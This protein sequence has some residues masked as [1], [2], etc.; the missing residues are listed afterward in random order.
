MNYIIRLERGHIMGKKRINKILFVVLLVIFLGAGA[1]FWYIND[2]YHSDEDVKNYLKGNEK[3]SVNEISQGLFIDGE[4]TENALIFYPGAKVEYIAYLPML[5]NMA[6]QGIDCFLIEMPCNLAFLG[7][8]TAD[9]IIRTYDYENWYMSGH[10]LGGAMA[11]VYASEHLDEL[12]GLVLLAA[13]PTK[14]L[15]ND[16]FEVL[17]IYGSEDTVLNMNSF[18]EGLKYMPVNYKEVCIEGGNHAYFGNY[19]EQEG[20]SKALISRE[21]QQEQTMRAVLE[22]ME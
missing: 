3:V 17:S 15:D 12:E 6:E 10:S 22:I 1:A 4:G 20:D 14:S 16:K 21:E 19:G 18:E 8:N 13:Y 2:Y 11:A 9:S 5:F 7:K